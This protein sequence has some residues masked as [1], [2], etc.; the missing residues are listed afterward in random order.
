ML[1]PG[2]LALFD[3]QI[4]WMRTKK[5]LSG[6]R[7]R[8]VSCA[9]ISIL[10]HDSTLRRWLDKMIIVWKNTVKF[11]RGIC[12]FFN[13]NHYLYHYRDKI[14][15]ISYWST[16]LLTLTLHTHWEKA[17][18]IWGVFDHFFVRSKESGILEFPS[19]DQRRTSSSYKDQI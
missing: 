7:C 10:S 3:I 13:E 6:K 4:D 12:N 9:H 2:K 19:G 17:I 14:M 15:Q 5:Y 1:P 18:G 11:K 8:E 16:L